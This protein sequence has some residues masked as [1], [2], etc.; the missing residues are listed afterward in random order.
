MRDWSYQLPANKIPAVTLCHELRFDEWKQIVQHLSGLISEKYPGA[1]TISI[2]GAEADPAL[3]HAEL[4]TIPMFEPARF[5]VISHAEQLLNLAAQDKTVLQAFKH[6]LANLSGTTFLILQLSKPELPA[7]WKFLA[8]KAKRIGPEKI[9]DYEIASKLMEHAKLTGFALE[10][11]T[12]ELIAERSLF[13]WEKSLRL[14]DQCLL[15]CLEEKKIEPQDVMAVSAD[16]SGNV[17]FQILDALAERNIELCIEL[18][19]KHA[20]ESPELTLF[21]WVK[22]FN[23]LSRFQL[24]RD[25]PQD[26]LWQ[27]L[28]F[29]R[30]RQYVFKKNVERLKKMDRYY[31]PA[32]TRKVIHK[33]V[34]L[35]EKVKSSG[36]KAEQTMVCLSFLLYLKTA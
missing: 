6:D 20:V 2:S 21:Q 29:N 27:K 26:L 25:L 18:F 15:Y 14:F 24:W 13:T 4:S 5:L 9:N 3:F 30:N 16:E 36:N 10:K 33:L 34:A 8:E 32:N 35:D 31:T 12:A 22:L 11:D 28:D 19:Q 1:E 23:E 17:H 7:A